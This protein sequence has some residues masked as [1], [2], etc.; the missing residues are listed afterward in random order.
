MR[1]LV[2]LLATLLAFAL[3]DPGRAQEDSTFLSRMIQNQLSSAG[4][5]VRISGFAGALSSRATMTE[6]T[7]A[8]D[9]GIWFTARNVVLDWSRTALLRGR[10]QVSEFSA[11]ELVVA[12]RPVASGGPDLPSAEAQPFSL[13]ELPVSVEIRA[14]HIDRLELGPDIVGQPVVARAQGSANLNGGE[15]AIDLT[16]RRTDGQQGDFVVKGSF[17]NATRQLALQLQLSEGQG[18]IA[19]TMIGF[20]GQPAIDMSVQGEG[21]IDD[22]TADIRVATANQTRLG[23]QVVTRTEDAP[24]GAPPGQ[25]RRFILDLGGDVRPMLPEDYQAFFGPDVTVNAV[26]VMQADGAVDV[27]EIVLGAAALD[28]TGRV[29]VAKTGVPG[30]IRLDGAIRP[31]AGQAGPV[32]LPLTGTRTEVEGARLAVLYDS[33]AGNE[34]TADIRVNG[35]RQDQIAIGELALTGGGTI[36]HPTETQGREVSGQLRFDATGLAPTDPAL[37]EATGDSLTGRTVF[38]WKQGEGLLR[39]PVLSINGADFTARADASIAGLQSQLH[40]SGT[41]EAQ[42]AD[43]ARFSALAGRPLSGQ[44]RAKAAGFYEPLSGRFDL[45]ADVD[46]QD[47]TVGQEQADRMLAGATVIHLSALRDESGTRLR[48]ARLN[49]QTLSVEAAGL[50]S[51]GATDVTARAV[52]ADAGVLGEGYGGRFAA[53]ARVWQAP[54]GLRATFDAEG[55]DLA[56]GQPQ[57][58]GLLRGASHIR[59][60]VLRQGEAVVVENFDLAAASLT[61]TAAGRWQPGATDLTARL[62]FADAGVLGPGYGGRFT[63]DATAQDTGQGLRVTL[64]ADGQNLA[65]G[66]PQVDALLRGNSQVRLAAVRQ[67]EAIRIENLTVSAPAID[68]RASGLY[69]PGAT[70]ISGDLALNNLRA[71]GAGLNGSLTLTARAAEEPAGLRLTA[72]GRAQNLAVGQPQADALMRGTSRFDLN[73]VRAADGMIRIDRL[74][75]ANP[76]V[77]LNATGRVE[78]EVRRLSIDGRLA[79]LA[80]LVPNFSGPVTLTGEVVEQ[81]GEARVDARMRGPGQIDA[82][83]T[84][85]VA[86][87]MSTSNVTI[88]GSSQLGLANAFISPRSVQGNLRFDLRMQGRPGLDALSGTATASQVRFVEPTLG[89]VLTGGQATAR[90]DGGRAT[91]DARTQVQGGGSISAAG[92]LGLTAPFPADLTIDLSAAQLRDPEL[93]T[94]TIN[95]RIRITGPMTGGGLIAGNLALG[96]T[97]FRVPSSLGGTA[98]IPDGMVHRAEPRPVRLTR[99]RAGLTGEGGREEVRGSGAFRL[100]VAVSAPNRIF[101]RGRGLDAELGGEIRLGGT[102]AN[103]VPAGQF[104]LIRG[105]L[106]FLDRR[107]D[108]TEGHISLQG[109]F[110]PYVHLVARSTMRSGLTASVSVIGPIDDPDITI[111]SNPELPEEEVLSQVIFGRDLSSIS[112]LQA[113]QLASAVA[114]LAGRGGEG[115]VSRLRRNFGLDNL[116]LVT[117]DEGGAAVRAGR[118]VSK[119]VYTEVVVGNSTSEINLNLDV[120]PSLTLRGTLGQ[121][122]STGVGVFFEK[123][124]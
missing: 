6:M 48:E 74:D 71:L 30:Y 115:I 23:G 80:L 12:R 61:A 81:G 98:A 50:I 24:P 97:E 99:E 120:T 47:L 7:I 90:L 82:R 45:V 36:V 32:L 110:T 16:L 34:W 21:S 17:A 101:V 109:S 52:F 11:E 78:G 96:N 105:R 116:D 123:D 18:G 103:P 54:E 94:T 58:N 73:A 55:Q 46:G 100:D 38:S 5:E 26:A 33:G 2:L 119:N 121:D 108:L 113:A 89:V 25:R 39:L 60:S 62:V 19:T 102:T 111:S 76:Q 85:T 122:G 124:Y 14:F 44:A 63:A 13:P 68:G 49:A 84:G 91:I 118:Y 57:V 67:G 93:Y 53:D 65:I 8:D 31:P 75:F 1:Y 70:D 10:F 29:V 20:P 43:I 72:Q 117:D 107:F 3:P 112:P 15:G 114:T 64:A 83:A 40:L 87:D 104:D 92:T 22:F 95:G 27:D 37:A 41:V 4:R 42:M 28:L 35:L 77:T 66:Q 59:A 88:T 9:Q 86:T 69:Q 51:S 79:N 56:V 106:D